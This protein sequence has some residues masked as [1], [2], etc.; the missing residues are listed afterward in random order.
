MEHLP[1]VY[2]R[3]AAVGCAPAACCVSG[4]DSFCCGGAVGPSPGEAV[5]VVALFVAAV[6]AAVSVSERARFS[7]GSPLGCSSTSTAED[8]RTRPSMLSDD[9]GSAAH[10]TVPSQYLSSSF[11]LGTTTLLQPNV[12]ARV[13]VWGL[14]VEGSS[15]SVTALLWSRSRQPFE[16]QA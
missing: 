7:E 10:G 13:R 4:W 3:A 5:V 11:C 12:G 2:K 9:T 15:R 16:A 6:V 8:A 1:H 14:Q